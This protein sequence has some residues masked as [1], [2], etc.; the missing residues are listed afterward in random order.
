MF[1]DTRPGIRIYESSSQIADDVIGSVER[2]VRSD[3]E[4]AH[5][6]E[7]GEKRAAPASAIA[8]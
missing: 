4:H 3:S 5:M 7:K 6:G 1:G 2:H 8:A